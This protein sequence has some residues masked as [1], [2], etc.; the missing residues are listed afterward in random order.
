M[1]ENRVRISFTDTGSGLSTNDGKEVNG[2][3]I[4]GEDKKFYWAKAIIEGDAVVVYSDKVAHPKAVRYAWADNP[5]CNVVNSAGLPVV[6][7]RTDDWKGI[8]QKE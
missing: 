8:T 4:A 1:K 2:F 3:S 5:E 6:P 7:F